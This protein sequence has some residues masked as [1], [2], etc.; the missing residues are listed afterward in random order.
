TR[1]GKY[2]QTQQRDHPETER[3]PDQRSLRYGTIVR[4]DGTPPRG[5]HSAVRPNLS[6]AVAERSTVPVGASSG[7]THLVFHMPGR[8]GM[9]LPSGVL[10]G[11]P[12]NSVGRSRV[13]P[14]EP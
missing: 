8:S 9:S 10:C 6:R 1:A 3:I 12:R 5:F 14:P 13:F 7:T 4:N 2:T 11:T